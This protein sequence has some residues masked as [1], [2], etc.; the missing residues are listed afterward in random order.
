MKLNRL[1]AFIVLAGLPAMARDSIHEL[2]LST[3]LHRFLSSN[4]M[5]ITEADMRSYSSIIPHTNVTFRMV[6]VRGGEFLMGSPAGEAHRKP[7]EGPQH[8]VRLEPF[9]IGAHE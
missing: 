4:L 5:E 1:L 8:R 6:S 3:N 2:T 7:D 9:W